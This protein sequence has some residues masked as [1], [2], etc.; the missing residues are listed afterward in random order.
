M[1]GV[2]VIYWINLDRATERRSHM[3]KV[4]SNKSLEI[5]PKIRVS[6][7]DS[8]K[9]EL[10][11]YFTMKKDILSVNFRV[12]KNEYACLLSHLETIRTFADSEYS[13]ALI[14]EDD[15]VFHKKTDTVQ[16]VIDNAPKDWEIIRLSSNRFMNGPKKKYRTFTVKCNSTQCIADWGAQAYLITK[17]AAK[18]IIHELYHKKYLLKNDTFHVA[19]YLLFDKLKTYTYKENFFTIRKNNVSFIQTRKKCRP[20]I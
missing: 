11:D 6:A 1:E 15:V 8:K 14:L 7:F 18:K 10:D 4:L 2:D 5:I 19:D 12:T 20:T 13:T 17:N 3:K 9:I 16:H